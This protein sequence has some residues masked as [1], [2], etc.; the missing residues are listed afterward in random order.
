MNKPSDGERAKRKSGERFFL[1]RLPVAFLLTPICI[2]NR[3]VF[4]TYAAELNITSQLSLLIIFFTLG[5]LVVY[6]SS[7][8][9]QERD[10][11]GTRGF[12][13]GAQLQRI[14]TR[15]VGGGG[16][17]EPILRGTNLHIFLP[18]STT[19]TPVILRIVTMVEQVQYVD[20]GLCLTLTSDSWLASLSSFS[21]NTFKHPAWHGGKRKYQIPVRGM[22]SNIPVKV[23]LSRK[24][25][26]NGLLSIPERMSGMQRGCKLNCPIF[27]L[28]PLV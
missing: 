25:S 6:P 26:M 4:L 24:M 18:K 3:K 9:N 27:D 17:E 8:F 11:L 15:P 21:R 22:C 20:S 23:N 13:C 2:P 5:V 28:K 14:D 16:G 19:I 1:A 12:P 10:I 7:D